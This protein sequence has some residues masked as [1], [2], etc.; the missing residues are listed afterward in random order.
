MPIN[1]LALFIL[2]VFLWLPLCY[3][4]WYYTANETTLAIAYL[5]KILLNSSF[6]L[7]I[8][9]IEQVSTHF[10]IVVNIT[11]PAAQV[12]KGMVAELPIPINP[13]IYSHGLPLGLSLILASPFSYC[14]TPLNLVLILLI[15]IPFQ[16]FGICFEFMKTLFLQTPKELTSYVKLY[17]WQLD[18]IAVGY[19]MGSLVLPTIVPIIIWLFLYRDFI[20]QF[21]PTLQKIINKP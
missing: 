13:L 15:S 5:T 12:P 8:S 7:L 20:V 9:G 3:W 18:G 2:K 17:S 1:S 6:P 19:Q 4:G 14:K 16:I 10:D 11:L 21:V